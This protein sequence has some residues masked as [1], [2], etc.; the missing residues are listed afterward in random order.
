M[1]YPVKGKTY[2]IFTTPNIVPLGHNVRKQFI[3]SLIRLRLSTIFASEKYTIEKT[4]VTYYS[5]VV[6]LLIIMR[7]GP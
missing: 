6:R 7:T 4:H 5:F 2:R 3:S 1:I